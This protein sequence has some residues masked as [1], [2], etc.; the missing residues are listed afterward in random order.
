MGEGAGLHRARGA[1]RLAL[2]RA[3]GRPQCRGRAAG[4][5]VL[6]GGQ[7]FDAP[8]PWWPPEPRPALEHAPL[9]PRPRPAHALIILA[10]MLRGARSASLGVLAAHESYTYALLDARCN[11]FTSIFTPRPLHQRK[12]TEPSPQ[13]NSA[14]IRQASLSPHLLHT[15]QQLDAHERPYVRSASGQPHYYRAARRAS[16]R[17]RCP[18]SSR[19]ARRARQRAVG[20]RL[21]ACRSAWGRPRLAGVPSAPPAA[22]HGWSRASRPATPAASPTASR[23]TRARCRS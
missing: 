3:R 5:R 13:R 7:A 22:S 23:R 6:Q 14:K 2:L 16:L 12:R 15:L 4:T 18:P 11:R 19:R 17:T 10:G 21:V 1:G 20:A 8:R 9:S